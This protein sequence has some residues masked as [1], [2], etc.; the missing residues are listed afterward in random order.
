MRATSDSVWKDDSSNSPEV[1]SQCPGLYQASPKCFGKHA[2]YFYSHIAIRTG[3]P[4]SPQLSILPHINT[5][6][7]IVGSCSCCLMLY[8]V[9]QFI[10]DRQ[11]A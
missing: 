9:P 10:F 4:V 5:R 6:E 8:H 11:N 7:I 2:V 1:E 3:F